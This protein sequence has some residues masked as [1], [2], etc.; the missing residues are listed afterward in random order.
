MPSERQI[1][2]D[3]RACPK[4]GGRMQWYR[5]E[6]AKTSQT[7]KHVFSCTDCGSLSSISTVAA[8]VSEVDPHMGDDVLS[9]F[10]CDWLC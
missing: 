8:V 9:A 3:D 10:R 1:N 4:C 2:S 5:S 7:I 6:A